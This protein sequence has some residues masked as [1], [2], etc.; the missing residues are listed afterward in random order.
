MPNTSTQAALDGLAISLLDLAVGSGPLALI[1]LTYVGE[2]LA[3][4]FDLPAPVR[5]WTRRV[6]LPVLDG[7]VACLLEEIP[8][9]SPSVG[10]DD[11]HGAFAARRRLE[12]DHVVVAVLRACV[13]QDVVPVTALPTWGALHAALRAYDARVAG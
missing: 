3:A 2:A 1:P 13:A 12:A 10:E 6:P 11:P 9:W 4:G 5:A 7:A 8:S